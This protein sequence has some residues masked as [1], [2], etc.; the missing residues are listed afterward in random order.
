VK[1]RYRERYTWREDKE[2]DVNS[3]WV[4]RKREDSAVLKGKHY[5]ALCGELVLEEAL[6]P[7]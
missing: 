4:L 6:D 5:V 7:S 1:E 3:Y 2:D